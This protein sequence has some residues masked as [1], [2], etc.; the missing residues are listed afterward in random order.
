MRVNVMQDTQP[1]PLIDTLLL[2]CDCS[3]IEALSQ[4]SGF[5][6]MMSFLRYFIW[7]GLSPDYSDFLKQLHHVWNFEKKIRLRTRTESLMPWSIDSIEGGSL[8]GKRAALYN[9]GF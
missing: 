5:D 8:S 1:D 7:E 2:F 3:D 6:L 9:L 4:V